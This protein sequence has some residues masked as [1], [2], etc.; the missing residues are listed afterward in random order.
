MIKVYKTDLE[1]NLNLL[2]HSSVF[3]NNQIMNDIV[4]PLGMQHVPHTSKP[5]AVS[6]QYNL[7]T[8]LMPPIFELKESIAGYFKNNV[9]HDKEQSYW[10]VG[11]L[12]FWP[13]KGETLPWHGHEY[14]DDENCFHGY[15]GVD[16]EPS[17]TY[18]RTLGSDNVEV[19]IKNLDRQLVITN[20]KGVEHRTSNWNES[21]PRITIAFNIQPRETVL[22]EVGNR[23]N[24]YVPL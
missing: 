15:V 21:R 22:Q 17:E 16:C 23:L 12:N 11:W 13:N 10:I 5:T 20:S 14:G 8:S 24:Y 2:K 19:T 6:Q 18:Y 1:C 9:D 4:M 3:L 7:F